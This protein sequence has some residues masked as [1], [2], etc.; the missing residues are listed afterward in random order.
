M[1][2]NKMLYFL[3]VNYYSGELIKKLISS[4]RSASD[5][6]YKIIIVNNSKDD[7]SLRAGDDNSVTVIESPD[8]L[9]FGGGCNLG[10]EYVYRIDRSALIW[11]INP[12]ATLD[13]GAPRYIDR[14]FQENP[15]LAILGTKIR[16]STEKIWFSGGSFQPFLGTLKHEARMTDALDHLIGLVP[17]RWVS[18][19]SLIL[20]LAVFDHCPKF[21]TRYFL[22][23]EDVDLCERYYRQKYIVAITKQVL[24]THAVSAIIGKNI[25]FM[26]EQ[27]TFSRLL[28]LALHGSQLSFIL[29][30]LY[31]SVK[32]SSLLFSDYPNARGRYL[33]IQK[34]FLEK[35][36]NL[37]ETF[38]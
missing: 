34:Y 11:L 8:N 25:Q 26:F 29:Y 12:D 6:D 15:N 32:I 28:F 7:L 2:K 38:E 14:C 10:I 21:D 9:G 17:T 3:T 33:G 35:A 23:H 18:G 37:S 36:K 24:V 13:K 19:C 30:L 22:Y 27:Y 16:D 20:N 4:I 31:A 5:S 1:T